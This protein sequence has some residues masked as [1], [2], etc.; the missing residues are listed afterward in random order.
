VALTAC[1]PRSR[2]APP[3]GVLGRVREQKPP[4]V[5]AVLAPALSLACAQRLVGRPAQVV[6]LLAGDAPLERRL[7]PDGSNRYHLHALALLEWRQTAPARGSV[8]GLSS[9]LMLA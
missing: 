2:L 3:F 5:K 9:R 4:R 8:R 6:V 1:G 7:T